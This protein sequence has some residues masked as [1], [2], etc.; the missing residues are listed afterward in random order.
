[1]PTAVYPV[2]SSIFMTSLTM[3]R[4]RAGITHLIWGCI[5]FQQRQIIATS[6]DHERLRL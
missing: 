1:M 4:V 5:A 6:T 2:L 3:L